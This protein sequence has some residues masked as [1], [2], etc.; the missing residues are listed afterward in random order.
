MPIRDWSQVGAG[1]FHDFRHGWIE[2]IKRALNSGLLPDDYYALAEQHTAGFGPD[3]LTLQGPPTNAADDGDGPARMPSRG[4]GTGLLPAPPKVRITAETDLE[5]NQRKH[6]TVTVRHASGDR[7]VARVE[8]VSPGNKAGRHAVRAFIEKAAAL[9]EKRIHL[10]ILDLQPPGSLAPQ[11]IHGCIWS[12]LTGE[13]C[14][15]PDDK[16][17]TLAAYESSDT[18]RAYVEPVAVGDVLPAMPLFLEP[19]DY[20][21]VP[22]EA[23]CESAYA[24]VPRRW[25]EV[26]DGG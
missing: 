23:T 16:P 10:L 11:G 21:N 12:Y 5:F 19:R 17:L 4:A 14:E 2:E 6:V 3:V 8:I 13:E 24:A 15:A 7:V 25:R 18:L 1:V 26:L 20:I 9:L 22:L